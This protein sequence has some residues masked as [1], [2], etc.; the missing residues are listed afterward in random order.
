MSERAWP[1]T[2]SR[3]LSQIR[4]ADDGDSWSEFVRVYG[5]LVYRYCVH[6]GLQDADAH[7]VAQEVLATV[8]NA[9]GAF[10][11]D[12]KKGRFRGWLGTIVR[13]AIHAQAQKANRPDRGVGGSSDSFLQQV[14]S[15]VDPEWIEVFNAHIY[16]V[17]LER[18]R[19]RLGEEAWRA[20]REVW[21]E[22]RKPAEV[23]RRMERKPDWVYK[24]KFRG[25]RQLERE[26]VDLAADD[27]ILTEG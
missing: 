12:R 25:L 27:A 16:Q 22:D 24:A 23:A 11:Y 26:I 13:H 8:A 21:L 10:R 17:A 2:S 7:D 5:P 15:A 18:V 4:Q 14:E 20:F 9:I 1:T 6:R 3:L 19:E